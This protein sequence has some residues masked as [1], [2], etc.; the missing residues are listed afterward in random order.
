M[1]DYYTKAKELASRLGY[2]K[3]T[4]LQKKAFENDDVL[5]EN[6][7]WIFVIGDTSSG[8]TL[9]PLMY[10]FLQKM[11]GKQL[12]MLFA[13]P[14]RALA[15][16]KYR[17]ISLLA[18]RL[19]VNLQ[20]EVSTGELRT[21]DVSIRSG[22]VDIA[23]VI[24]E[25]IFMFAC[26]DEDFLRKYQILVMD[27]IGLTQDVS[28][29]MKADFVLTRA[30]R[31][32][33]LRVFALGTPYYDWSI[34][35][36]TYNF[37][38][39]KENK[40]PI[41]LKTFPIF[42][43]NKKYIDYVDENCKSVTCGP[44]FYYKNRQDDPNPRQWWDEIIEDICAYHLE[45]GHKIL[46]FIN[47]R[48]EV[49]KLSQRLCTTLVNR[50]RLKQWINVENVS[51]Y[52]LEKMQFEKEDVEG[53]LYGIFEEKDYDA[54]SYGVSY[55]NAAVPN[56]LRTLVENE[57]LKNNGHL[58]I[59]CCTETLA[60]GI[61]SNVDVV[62]IPDMIKQRAGENPSSGFLRANEYMNY[63]GRAGR[64]QPNSDKKQVGYIYPIIKAQY[65]KKGG[66]KVCNQR[67]AWEALLKE[68]ENPSKVFSRYFN[69]DN[70]EKPFYLLSLFPNVSGGR[71]KMSLTQIVNMIQS[72][73]KSMANRFDLWNDVLL[74]LKYLLEKRL[75][76]KADIDED[77]TDEDEEDEYYLTDTGAL[78][79]G[80][81][82]RQDDFE[83]LLLSVEN[84]VDIK[85]I[86][87]ADL[88]YSILSGKEMR[89]D[90]SNSIGNLH[91]IEGN[92]FEKI[93]INTGRQL[94]T[95][96]ENLSVQMK[97]KVKDILGIDLMNT[98]PTLDELQLKKEYNQCN[99]LRI[100][101]A[102]LFWISPDCTVKKLYDRFG[103]GYP[104]MQ[105]LAE[106]I[107]YHLDIA[108]FSIPIIRTEEDD[109][110]IKILGRDRV[111]EI[112]DKISVLSQAIYF[113]IAPQM[114][115]KFK[116]EVT[117]PISAVI[118]RR[119]TRIYMRLWRIMSKVQSGKSMSRKE[120]KF[121]QESRQKIDR[122]EDDQRKVFEQFWEVLS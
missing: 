39:I 65:R 10:Y 49:H 78:L 58:C 43:S 88:I 23:V 105:K 114:C 77:L 42:V 115:E 82:I 61:N 8:K 28:R 70:E 84:G 53:D 111:K 110:L 90:I 86:W 119:L 75:I 118:A 99:L 67:S 103:I 73:P 121:I 24:Y 29:G 51:E 37:I 74:P 13:V 116:I 76:C 14:Y 38:C 85:N 15:M 18:E 71:K 62:I 72:L 81:I 48:E 104:Q 102:L 109:T 93:M 117:D 101:A 45:Q 54:F 57:I 59:V 46:I 106:K 3:Y 27:E 41:D 32:K 97:N 55:H 22:D 4:E 36:E 122:L 40:R 26:M 69:A 98:R 31:Y 95:D 80:F 6:S 9:I 47:N 17:E 66:E 60:Y 34:Y 20:I 25:K 19:E 30:Q 2:E 44:L 21:A 112:Q 87:S 83:N 96:R 5:K 92:K 120:Q 94:W 64:L 89:H 16:Q 56:A 12:R 7:S 108:K 113:Q 50:G 107:S 63:A 52:I 1:S 79:T 68:I 11:E 91:K 35:Q 33:Q 100:M